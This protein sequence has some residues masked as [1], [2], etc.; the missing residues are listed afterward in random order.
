MKRENLIFIICFYAQSYSISKVVHNSL[1]E[2]HEVFYFA[3]KIFFRSA[4]KAE[5]EENQRSY[6]QKKKRRRIKVQEDSSS[7]NK[8]MMTFVMCLNYNWYT[9]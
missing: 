2:I 8:V 4:K 3:F 7:E 1:K 5:L 9:I 6:K